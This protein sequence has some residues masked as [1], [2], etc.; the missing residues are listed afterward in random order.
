M[1]TTFTLPA[2]KERNRTVARFTHNGE[3]YTIHERT[4]WTSQG[5]KFTRRFICDSEGNHRGAASNVREA[6]TVL[7]DQAIAKATA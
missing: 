4:N 2:P 3:D 6:R 7:N 5:Y 1:R